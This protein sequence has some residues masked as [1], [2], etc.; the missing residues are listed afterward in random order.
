MERK[1]SGSAEGILYTVYR[2]NR[3]T[4]SIR[5]TSEEQVEV[6][7]PLWMSRQAIQAFVDSKAAWIQR[8]LTEMDAKNRQCERIG[9]DDGQVL[10]LLGKNRVVHIAAVGEPIFSDT[11]ILLPSSYT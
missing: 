1:E 6:R 11:E 10:P 5:I 9:W 4:C 8:H 2:S 7:A 3:K